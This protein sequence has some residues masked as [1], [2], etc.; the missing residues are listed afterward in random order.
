MGFTV[1]VADA[2]SLESAADVAVTVTTWAAA[3]VAGAVNT[4]A[5]VIV[6]VVELPPT[7]PL[8][9]QVTTVFV[10]F[11]T[12]AVKV[13]DAAASSVA[14]G[15]STVTFT[16]RGGTTAAR[17]AFVPALAGAVV[18]T[19]LEVS[20]TSAESCLPASSMTVTVAVILP[21]VGAMNVAAAWFGGVV[22][23]VPAHV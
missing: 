23:P 5:V 21:D 8:T 22:R 10:V 6:P 19:V 18:A 17:H 20:T 16:G 9:L 3:T 15:G 11:V 7:I 4:P 12:V 14:V 13:W 1:T 2:V